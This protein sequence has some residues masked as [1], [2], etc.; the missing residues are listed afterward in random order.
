[1]SPSKAKED[2]TDPNDDPELQV[3]IW[4]VQFDE[5]AAYFIRVAIDPAPSTN[6]K[7]KQPQYRTEVAEHS[8]R[9]EFKTRR[10]VLPLP[11]QH[12]KQRGLK[13]LLG[14]PH[15]PPELVCFACQVKKHPPSA[16]IVGEAVFPLQ[17][18]L[19]RLIAG[20]A[21][22]TKL[23]FL[24]PA[25]PEQLQNPVKSPPREAIGE[26]N[27]EVRFVAN[28]AATN[29]AQETGRVP[30]P[31]QKHPQDEK[32][33]ADALPRRT[34]DPY[35]DSRNLDAAPI[36]DFDTLME[37]ARVRREIFPEQLDLDSEPPP[38]RRQPIQ[39]SQ[40]PF[41]QTS[42]QSDPLTNRLVQELDQ[43]G[44]GMQK[45]GR[46]LVRLRTVN[47]E[48]EAHVN[49]LQAQLATA[50][51]TTTMFMRAVDVDL[52][53]PEELRRRYAAV[54]QKLQQA[55]EDA[56]KL[57]T[58]LATAQLVKMERNDLE[59]QLLE[60]RSA[61]TAQQMYLQKL[62]EKVQVTGKVQA[63]VDK[64]ERVIAALE[65]MLR[66]ATDSRIRHP[67]RGWDPRSVTTP[68]RGA[69]SCKCI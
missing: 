24:L 26:L 66:K 7:D 57:E 39:Q 37:S 46:E 53:S 4:G 49:R 68:V 3:R 32:S 14:D 40:P 54:L 47:A 15:F 45:M 16:Q 43:R 12:K 36:L 41:Q 63:V 1:M 5:P 60:L 18:V 69:P 44:E 20:E 64:Q 11:P 35:A 58:E 34:Q 62:Q 22:V 61:H 9:P 31:L 8:V 30:Q 48:L 56:R 65:E 50:D 10:W 21:L 33:A 55:G 13:W 28:R 51:D 25:T 2:I 67:V 6:D 19:E 52:L 38:K 29:T 23:Q 42:L 17:P 27:L 59:R